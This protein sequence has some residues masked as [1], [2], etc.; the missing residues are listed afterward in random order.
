MSS[1]AKIDDEHTRRIKRTSLKNANLLPE[2]AGNLQLT[3]SEFIQYVVATESSKNLD[4][5][6][7]RHTAFIK[8]IRQS[9][10]AENHDQLLK[11]IETLSLEKYVDEIAGAV[12]EG[13]TRCKTE[14]DVWS[15][16]EVCSNNLQLRSNG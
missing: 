5:S 4:S 16:V 7:K 9:A 12:V 13:I 2:S 10:G 15:A 1:A 11:D 8:R 14:K 6:L 3:P